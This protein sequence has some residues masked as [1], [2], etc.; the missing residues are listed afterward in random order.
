MANHKSS[1]ARIL[2]NA[3]AADV[4]TMR[5][6]AMRTAVKKVETAIATGDVASAKT[7]LSAAQPHL[8][9]NAAK[10]IVDKK[11]AARKVSRLSARIK[12]IETKAA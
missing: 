3:K 8:Q 6:S 12:A 4:N 10:G 1:K 9:R 2:R 11:A 5:K 7:A